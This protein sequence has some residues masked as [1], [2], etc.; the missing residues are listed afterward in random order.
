LIVVGHIPGRIE[1]VADISDFG[2]G[3]LNPAQKESQNRSWLCLEFSPKLFDLFPQAR[4]YIPGF[5]VA[6]GKSIAVGTG[7]HLFFP[8]AFSHRATT[9]IRRT[10]CGL[11][12]AA[13]AG[14]RISPLR[15][16]FL[17]MDAAIGYP[18]EINAAL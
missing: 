13:V 16:C 9:T 11:R 4:V 5:L 2:T 6:S 10:F 18:A 12:L 1:P 15:T 7:E 14:L 3:D 8:G 17:A